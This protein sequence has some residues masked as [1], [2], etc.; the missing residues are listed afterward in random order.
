[1]AITESQDEALREEADP[2]VDSLAALRDRLAGASDEL[3]KV[4]D[5]ARW[6]E[7]TK[8]IPPV[9]FQVARETRALVERL[10]A[11]GGEGEKGDFR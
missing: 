6:K 1:M 3:N 2:I 4:G 7:S 5:G 9:A 10:E 8:G 11:L